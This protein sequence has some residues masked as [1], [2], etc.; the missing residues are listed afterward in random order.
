MRY[1]LASASPRRKELLK[2]IVDDF[3]IDAAQGEERSDPSLSPA[4]TAEYLAEQ[5]AREVAGKE[6]HKGKTV[7][8]ADT[9][10]TIDGKILGKPRSP[11]HA[12]EMLRLL[13][14][15]EHSVITGVC[16]IFS[17][18]KASISHDETKVRFLPFSEDFIKAYVA[19]GSPMDKAGAY[20]LQDGLPVAEV[21]G[22]EDNVVGLPTETLF[23]TLREGLP[24]SAR[25]GAIKSGIIKE[26]SV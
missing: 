15:R 5:K 19:G 11:A 8:G 26:G 10:V 6:R 9:V 21:V 14:G 16:V 22:S 24:E 13:S 17:D 1:V 3:E 25:N 4:Q 7:I 23:R 12:E 20:G 18:G 2:K